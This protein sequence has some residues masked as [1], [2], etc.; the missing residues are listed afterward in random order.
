MILPLDVGR[1]K[2]MKEEAMANN[3][4]ILI[5]RLQPYAPGVAKGMMMFTVVNGSKL[6]NGTRTFTAANGM[7]L[8]IASCPELDIGA[9]RLYLQGDCPDRD[10]TILVCDSELYNR[11]ARAVNEHNDIVPDDTAVKQTR[12]ALMSRM[13]TNI[14]RISKA[15]EQISGAKS[16]EALMYAKQVLMYEL[17]EAIPLNNT[18]CYYC[19]STETECW[20]CPYAKS[21]G[22]CANEDSV[23]M[24]ITR[25]RG[26]LRDAINSYV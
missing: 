1:Y 25:A 13:S 11:I 4:I 26:A 3:T 8:Q 17:V 18:E 2:K 14:D 7:K 12:D 24:R 19:V 6:R 5:D 22:N 20:A 23:Y 9:D 10:Q 15:M 16:A 21:H